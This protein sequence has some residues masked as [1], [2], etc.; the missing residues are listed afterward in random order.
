V[1]E[2]SG[3]DFSA[4]F[5]SYIRGTAP[6]PYGNPL[7]AAGLAL[8]VS[9]REG[10]PPTIGITPLPEDRGLKVFA[11]LPGGAAD[12]AG[13]GRDDVVIAVDDQPLATVDLNKRLKAYPPGAAVPFTVER[14]GRQ[15]II[16]ITLDPPLP[17][18]Y[19]IQELPG[20]TPQQIAI[21]NRWLTGRN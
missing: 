11:V 13:L 8:R 5:D 10:S 7:A 9:V 21:R 14:H 18:F 17:N 2:V 15:E 16:Y 20:A 3:S 12:R 19:S 1:N 6:L 4:F